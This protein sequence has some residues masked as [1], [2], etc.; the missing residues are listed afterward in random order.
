M[1]FFSG[2]TIGKGLNRGLATLVAGG[3][4]L[5]AQYL[6]SKTGKIGEP[7]LIGLFVF[8]Q[9]LNLCYYVFSVSTRTYCDTDKIKL[10]QYNFCDCL[11]FSWG[12]DVC[13]I[14]SKCEG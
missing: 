6:A 14:L 10:T 5:G 4:G 9:G 2:A 7:I 1:F 8:L 12:V 11:I 13:T 3:L